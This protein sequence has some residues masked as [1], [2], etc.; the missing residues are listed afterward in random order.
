[1]I[2]KLPG[3]YPNRLFEATSEGVATYYLNQ[4]LDTYL[5]SSVI[6][7]RRLK[8]ERTEEMRTALANFVSEVDG[9]PYKY[10]AWQLV[11]ARMGTNEED[12]LNSLFCSQLIAEALKKMEILPKDLKSSNVLPMHFDERE[13]PSEGIEL[14]PI[15]ITFRSKLS[16]TTVFEQVGPSVKNSVDTSCI[17]S[18]EEFAVHSV[19]LSSAET[20]VDSKGRK[21]TVGSF[22]SH[23]K[24]Y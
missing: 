22:V 14:D 4:A 20:R 13:E 7:I 18:S 24:D 9:R 8:I 15:S 19:N 17:A 11:K 2:V 10:N 3:K 12:D 23:L 16:K 21:Y 1:M 5:S 6:A